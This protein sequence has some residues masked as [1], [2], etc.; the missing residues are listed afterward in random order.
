MNYSE[1]PCESYEKSGRAMVE[2]AVAEEESA[3][4]VVN[5]CATAPTKGITSPEVDIASR[6]QRNLVTVQ[7]KTKDGVTRPEVNG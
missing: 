2:G 4:G 7:T 1:L 3:I 5:E 6:V